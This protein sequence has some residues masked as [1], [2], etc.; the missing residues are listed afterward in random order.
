[1][2][3]CAFVQP[4]AYDKVGLLQARL[5]DVYPD[6]SATQIS[7]GL[8][9][10]VH[11][12]GLDQPRPLQPGEWTE[13][14]FVLNDIAQRVPAGHRLRLA[15]STQAWP[16]AWPAPQIMTLD[17]QADVSR[18][19][20]PTLTADQLRDHAIEARYEA[21][22][23]P[24]LAVDW[25]RPVTRERRVDRNRANNTVTRTYVKDDGAF[26]IVEH[27]LEIDTCGSLTYCSRGEDPLSPRARYHYRIAFV[28]DDWQVGVECEIEVTADRDNFHING[29][30]R[31]LEIGQLCKRRVIRIPVKRRHI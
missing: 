10:L 20:L 31:A 16:L 1:M 23:P 13:I 15:V 9:N 11:R 4:A 27:G 17:L 30:Y 22:I 3:P 21:E 6:G 25:K 2:R 12:D 14:R 5:C 28:R 24:P 26:R 19:E 8:L 7:Y 29:E 18:L